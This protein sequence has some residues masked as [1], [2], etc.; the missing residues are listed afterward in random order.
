MALPARSITEQDQRLDLL[1]EDARG[2]MEDTMDVRRDMC[3]AYLNWYSPPWNAHI[4]RHDAWE[5]PID[6]TEDLDTTRDNFPI[7]RAVVDI[8]TSL[9]AAKPPS[10]RA[11]PEHLSPPMPVLD[12]YKAAVLAEQY[13]LERTI[14]SRRSE[15]RTR[16]FK[17]YLRRDEFAL[18]HWKAV[19][20]K[21]LYGFSWQMVLPDARR[22]G[23]RSHILRNPTTV[24]PIWDSR[25]PDELE[26]VLSVQQMS[27]VRANAIYGL[28][29]QTDRDG[30]VVYGQEAAYGRYSEVDERY[31][32]DESRTKVWIE[33]YWW[34]EREYDRSTGMATSW[35]VH[36]AKRIC[37]RIVSHQTYPWYHLPF[38]YWSNEDERD[39]FGWSEV[40]GVMD[41]NDEFNRRMSEEGD[42]LSMYSHPRFQLLGALS[43][44]RDVELPGNDEIVTLED[45]ERI[46]QI[47]ARIDVYPVQVH[48]NTLI[49]L[50][51][52]VTGLPPIVWGLIANAQTS[53]RA[54]TASWKATEARLV[55]KLMSNRRSTNRYT[56]ITI[57][58]ARQYDW[59][60][61]A[62]IWAG[63]R[64]GQ[65]FDDIRWTSPPMEP[66]DFQ[67]VTMDAIT[68]RDA[69]LTTTIAAMRET[70]EENPEERL[71][72]VKVEFR[73]P[74]IHPE[75]AQAQVLYEDAILQTQE[76]KAAAQQQGALVQPN[77]PATVAQAV[78]QARQGAQGAPAQAP[79]GAEGALPPTAPGAPGNAGQPA[80]PDEES[81]TTGTLVRGGDVSNQMLRQTTIR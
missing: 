3:R 29:L 38:V 46:E 75:R 60:G 70:G 22:R 71:E 42:I 10:A 50:L 62:R 79:A 69:G 5:D 72:E 24:F 43:S 37:G 73:D 56:Q 53:G 52:R 64:S 17:E 65:V 39:E 47:L 80:P 25:D 4:A 61:G 54:L 26:A 33:D 13:A 34:A 55:P 36:N 76:R 12:R 16:A 51:H 59:D 74:A 35:R 7:S 1:I 81:V 30:M 8:W 40:A 15:I 57:D 23:P 19:R 18:K 77:S 32:Y 14:A 2:A 49:D 21:N 63:A 6:P 68:R 45:P 11:E 44:K 66:R 28:G 67:E 27:A 20:R 48:V 41:I 31:Y 58:Y 78:G 9:E